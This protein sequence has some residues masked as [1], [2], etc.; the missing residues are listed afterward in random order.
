MPMLATYRIVD[1]H[2]G[3][4][5]DPPADQASYHNFISR[6]SQGI[7]GYRAVLFLED[8]LADHHRRA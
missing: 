6:F 8:G 4:W 3:H 1:G 7:G 2:C 5:S